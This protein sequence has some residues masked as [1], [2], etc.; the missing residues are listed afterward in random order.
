MKEGGYR[1]IT[2]GYTKKIEETIL[3]LCPMDAGR[4]RKIT[5]QICIAGGCI[6]MLFLLLLFFRSPGLYSLALSVFYA[7]VVSEEVLRFVSK[8]LERRILRQMEKMLSDVRHFYY[9]TH[10]VV[11]ALQEAALV[12]GYEMRVHVE[13]LLEVL[14]S[15]NP[16]AAAEDYNRTSKNHFLKLFL[17]LCLAIQEYGDTEHKGESLFVRNLSALRKDILNQLLQIGRLQVEFGGLTMITLLP[18]LLLPLIRS[19]AIE[20]LPELS[21]FYSGTWGIVLPVLYLVFTVMIYRVIVEMQELDAQQYNQHLLLYRIER[22]RP[23]RAMLNQREKR[24]ATQYQQKK[25]IE[26]AGERITPRLLF[27][28]KILS[29]CASVLIGF[30]VLFY[31]KGGTAAFAWYELLIL[32][33]MGGFFYHIPDFRL[34]Y[35]RTLMKMNMLSEVTQ[36]QSIIMMQ[37]FIPDIT[38]LRILLTMEQFAFIFRAALQDCINEYSYS[39]YDALNGMKEAEQYRPFRRLCENLLSVDKIGII[40]SFEEVAQDREHF[41]MQ[42]EEETHNMIRKKAGKAR[43]IAFI[44]MLSVMVTYLILPY[45]IEAMSQFQAIL[46]E[47]GSM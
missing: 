22:I 1:K 11:D 46:T 29:L 19:T 41:Q 3:A 5:T 39:I 40:R 33:L 16:T 2:A 28:E 44:P 35:R 12:A 17:S 24:S 14:C 42:R 8:R 36:F 43:M 4:L 47:L 6:S 20:T 21:E 15:E 32:L 18:L 7:I 9:D 30:C 13:R 23:I 26:K 38:V 27:L 25:R 37:M 31:A 34:R 45:G 10:S